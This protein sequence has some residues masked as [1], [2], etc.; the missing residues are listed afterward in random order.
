MNNLMKT[1]T[2]SAVALTLTAAAPLEA[3]ANPLIIAPVVSAVVLGGAIVGGVLVGSVAA[4]S[5]HAEV[6][7]SAP[8]VSGYVEDTPADLFFCLHC[9]KKLTCNT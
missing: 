2:A 3:E 9:A 4:N 5:A 7:V 8:A 6:V 1:L